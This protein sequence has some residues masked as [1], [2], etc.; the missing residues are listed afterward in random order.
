MLRTGRLLSRCPR[1]S[2]ATSTQ[3]LKR[4]P[5]YDLHKLYGARMVP[6]AGF[7]MPVLYADL[8]LSESHLWTRANSSIFD[9]SHMVQF[10]LEGD[11]V[12]D[13]LES[14]TPSGI[15]ELEPGQGSLS[16]LLNDQGGIIDDTIITKQ[17]KTQFY[18]VTN[19]ACRDKDLAHIS[20]KL[21]NWGKPIHLKLLDDHGLIALQGPRSMEV[22]QAHTKEDLTSLKFGRSEYI[23]IDGVSCHVAR[24][25][26]TGEDGFEIS[27]PHTQ[28][29]SL[30][31][32]ILDTDTNAVKLAGL[33]PRDSLR[34]EAGMCLY[35]NDLN[36]S[37][38]PIEASLGWL[39]PKRRRLEGGFPGHARIK[40]DLDRSSLPSSP[41]S[42]S[43]STSSSVA[44]TAADD[45]LLPRR[46][47]GLTVSGAPARAGA[48][49]LDTETGAPIGV[50]TSGCPSP[51]LGVN[52]AMGYVRLGAHKSG[53]TCGVR[54]RSKVQQ[55]TVTKMPFVPTQYYK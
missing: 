25:G 54:V 7:E 23:D 44:S 33:G 53:T 5:L 42:T 32:S 34:L 52:I 45:T 40:L 29:A 49:I 47:V 50:V 10:K 22:L 8:G 36:D 39:I 1:R 20:E 28:T 18:I 3:P 55:G 31:Q 19:A 26:Y 2:Y 38:S 35:G 21:K 15:R 13:F 16:V 9:V 11:S 27:I 24:G 17:S 37:T 41:S 30:T 12:I 14:I 51:S 6:F 4:T 43:S 46:R 48:A